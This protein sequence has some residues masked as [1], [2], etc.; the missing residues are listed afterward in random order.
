MR[1]IGSGM[2]VGREMDSRLTV[3]VELTTLADKLDVDR[4]GQRGSK[5][6]SSHLA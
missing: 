2:S 1:Y 6:T 5:D 3:Q 4:K